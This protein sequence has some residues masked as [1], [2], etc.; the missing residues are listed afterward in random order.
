MSADRYIKLNSQPINACCRTM[1]GKNL[2]ELAF[3]L[4]GIGQ[5]SPNSFILYVWMDDGVRPMGV[6][7][8][9]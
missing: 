7:M 8:L 6:L 5:T 9:T 2:K 3:F 1:Q 4:L